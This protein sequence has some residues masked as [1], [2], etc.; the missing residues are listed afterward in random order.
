MYTTTDIK[1][2]THRTAL[3]IATPKSTRSVVA[4]TSDSE[5]LFDGDMIVDQ[6]THNR[7]AQIVESKLSWRLTASRR[8]ASQ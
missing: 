6:R 3:Q 5:G 2:I 8:D 7:P 4:M 1:P